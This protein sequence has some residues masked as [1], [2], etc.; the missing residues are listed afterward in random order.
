MQTQYLETSDGETLAYRFS[1]PTSGAITYVW[2]S[3]FNSD[4]QGGKAL[5]LADWAVDRGHGY[6]ALD[7]FGHGESSGAFAD[8]T[9]S[10]W[11]EDV[12]AVINAISEGPLVLVG[13][14]MGGWLALL[15]ALALKSRVAAL[16]L[17]A[18][19][20]DFTQKLMWPD[21]PKEGREAI[22]RD[23]VWMRPSPYGDPY[24]ITLNL[25]EDG[26]KWALL[27]DEIDLTV[28]VHILQG[29]EDP[30][31]PW[32]HAFRLVSVLKS[33]AVT[34]ELIKDGD[35]RLSRD[36]DIARLLVRADEMAHRIG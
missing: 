18:P 33:A 21:L 36:E 8:G 1:P 14:S 5:A 20:P 7:Y 26:R 24:P 32:D 31:V 30:D 6:L 12:L 16:L 2:L 23:G 13:S 28:P 10:R 9:V 35:H 4:M 17:I 34:F 15:T 11:R 29:M 3:G 25:I 22:Q 27:D 19:A